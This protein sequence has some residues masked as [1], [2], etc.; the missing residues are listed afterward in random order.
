MGWRGE[1]QG[2]GWQGNAGG[3]RWMQGNA[4]GME[5]EQTFL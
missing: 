5:Q 4:G 3:E 1:R 2:N